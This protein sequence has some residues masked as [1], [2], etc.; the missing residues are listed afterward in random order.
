MNSPRPATASSFL[1]AARGLIFLALAFGFF[2]AGCGKSVATLETRDV[3]F[4]AADGAIVNGTLY[5]AGEGSRVGLVLVHDRG[6]SRET[7]RT[8]AVKTQRSGYTSVAID[9]RGHGDST[10]PGGEQAA[11]K[12][13]T[14]QEWLAATND[15]AAAVEFLRRSG[16]DDKRIAVVGEGFGC[17]LAL[18]YAARHTAAAAAVLMSPDA[19]ERVV[20]MRE[21]LA[22]MGKRPVLLLGAE[23]DSYAAD[24]CTLLKKRAKGLCEVRL[25]PNAAHGAALFD[26]SATAQ[27]EYVSW[28]EQM[29][30]KAVDK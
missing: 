10:D 22:A 18:H 27:E 19:D 2:A 23:G 12:A 5:D 25:Y 13:F 14:P 28:L 9:L 16:V 8:A 6:G 21:E 4:T 24:S 1:V 20:D 3:A 11:F 26:A 17:A 30:E 7:W 15:I 29:V